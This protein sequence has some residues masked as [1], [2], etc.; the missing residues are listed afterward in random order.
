M[1]NLESPYQIPLRLGVF[2]IYILM[3]AKIESNIYDVVRKRKLKEG[4][5]IVGVAST[6]SG[7]KWNLV[8]SGKLKLMIPQ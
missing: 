8:H 3:V 2:C 7:K 1:P 6:M 4:E 5:K